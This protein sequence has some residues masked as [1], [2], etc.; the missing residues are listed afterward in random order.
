MCRILSLTLRTVVILAILTA[1]ALGLGASGLG[2]TP[3]SPYGSALAHFA[4]PS[5]YADPPNCPKTLCV[6]LPHGGLGC[7]STTLKV[8]CEPAGEDFCTNTPC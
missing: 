2:N 5:A 6:E 3:N 1:I 4:V 8:D 7:V